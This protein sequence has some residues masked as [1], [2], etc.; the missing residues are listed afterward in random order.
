MTDFL[1]NVEHGNSDVL[2]NA[3]PMEFRSDTE[4]KTI[5]ATLFTDSISSETENVNKNEKK[6]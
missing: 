5:E 6:M 3:T 2:S 4:H 1:Q